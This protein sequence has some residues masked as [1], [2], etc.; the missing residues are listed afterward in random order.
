MDSRTAQ[1]RR[2][3]MQSVKTKDTGPEIVVRKILHKAAYRYTTHAAKLPGRPDI[4]FNRRKKV[5]FVNGCFWHGHDCKKGALPKSRLEYWA[6]KI[7]RN[8]ERDAENLDKLREL[9]WQTLSIWQ[10]EID[11]RSDLVSTLVAF[12]G[13]PKNSIDIYK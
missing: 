12:L 9:G 1:Q 5:I 13:P 4:V 7:C 6:P 10:C 2:H 8:K 11:A 3:I